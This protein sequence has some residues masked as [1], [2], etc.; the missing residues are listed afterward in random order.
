MV[1]TDLSV[2]LILVC[3]AGSSWGLGKWMN[4]EGEIIAQ[5]EFSYH[6]FVGTWKLQVGSSRF[7]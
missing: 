3:L 6:Y 5:K 2:S 4:L 7:W 1:L